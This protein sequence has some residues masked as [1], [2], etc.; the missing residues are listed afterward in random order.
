MHSKC[1]WTTML[2]LGTTA[3]FMVFEFLKDP[4]PTHAAVLF[5]SYAAW[6]LVGWVAGY[7]FTRRAAR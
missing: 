6:V 7:F 4:T 1:F 3:L 2:Y 5:G